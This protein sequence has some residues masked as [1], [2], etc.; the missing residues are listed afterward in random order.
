[1][2]NNNAV[3][4]QGPNIVDLGGQQQGQQNALAAIESSRATQEVMASMLAAKRFPRDEIQAEQ[5]IMKACMRPGLAEE[6]IYEFTRGG[7][8][9][10]GPSIRLAESLKQY[11][12]NIDSGWR[13][14]ERRG[15]ESTVL[16]FAWDKE[17]NVRAERTF[18]VKQLRDVKEFIDGKPTGKRIQKPITDERDIYENNANQAARRMRACIL[19]LIPG[20]IVEGAVKQCEQTLVSKEK[21]TD[22]SIGAM[23]KGFAQF[24]VT[25]EMV[26]VFLGRKLTV[27]SV[28]PAMMVRLRNIFK[29]LKDGVAKV[30]DFFVITTVDGAAPAAADAA[31]D[32]KKPKSDKKKASEKKADAVDKKIDE[33]KQSFETENKDQLENFKKDQAEKGAASAKPKDCMTCVGSGVIHDADG[34]GPCPDCNGSGKI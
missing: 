31:G 16:A 30:Q 34:K 28:S 19:E 17:T 20:D 25:K 24:H 6:A 32:D 27:E 29:S 14:L 15:L 13:E 11:W 10:T 3:S 9:V 12:G 23:L 4:T 2:S 1:M 8:T 26:E 5:K 7:S 33:Q 21:V 22:E 18:T